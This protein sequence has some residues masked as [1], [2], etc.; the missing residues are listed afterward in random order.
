M[1]VEEIRW[2]TILFQTGQISKTAEMLFISQPALSQC[3]KRIEA[4][5]GFSLFE[6]SNKGLVP[7]E[8]GQLFYKTAIEITDSYQ[9]FLTQTSLLDQ[10][11]LHELTIGMGAYLSN[12]C[13]ADIVQRLQKAYPHIRFS[14]YEGSFEDMLRALRDN[15]VQIV[16]T[17]G[18]FSK[19][20]LVSYPFGR[21]PNV[22]FL[23]KGSPAAQYAY[24][25]NGRRYLDPKYL[26]DEPLALTK[27]DQASRQM[28]ENL[29]AEAGFKPRIEHESRHLAT[30]YRYASQGIASAIIPLTKIEEKRDQDFHLIHWI[31]ET[32]Q[33]ASYRST[34]IVQPEIDRIIPKQIYKIIWTAAQESEMYTKQ[35]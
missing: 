18:Q 21:I 17:T 4:Q 27:K 3:V 7:T 12:C 10:S 2:M 1:T 25:E 5:L 32:Y 13:S 23:R 19:D 11:E 35:I 24:T 8:R 30:V 22:I 15:I 26:E 28:A 31:P 9:K 29:I 34:I 6:R 20:G 16:V 33:W 14:V